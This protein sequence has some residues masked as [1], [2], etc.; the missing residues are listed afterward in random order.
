MLSNSDEEE[1]DLMFR[2]SPDFREE[3]KEE[4]FFMKHKNSM[5]PLSSNSYKEM[6]LS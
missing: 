6:R 1:H 2:Q 3:A 4:E 5:S